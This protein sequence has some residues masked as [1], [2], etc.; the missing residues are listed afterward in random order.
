VRSA[1]RSADIE[2]SGVGSALVG[3]DVELSILSASLQTLG[4]GSGGV[5]MLRGEPGVGKSRLI[6]EA[7]SRN[8]SEGVLWLEGRA[9]SFGHR[10]SY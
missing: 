8:S 2:P 1:D 7:K 9:L 4:V 5:V 3:R 6:A 10:L